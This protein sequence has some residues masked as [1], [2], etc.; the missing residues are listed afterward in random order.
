MSDNQYTD[1]IG[2]LRWMNNATTNEAADVIER[3]SQSRDDKSQPVGL[4]ARAP[5][6]R[7]A[8][9]STAADKQ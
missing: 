5:A 2:R 9:K 6:K 4:P 8:K 1:L 3:L 7:P